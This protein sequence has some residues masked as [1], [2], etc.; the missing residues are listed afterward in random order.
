MDFSNRLLTVK[1][2]PILKHLDGDERVGVGEVPADVEAKDAVD[3]T[4]GGDNFS[5][6]S[7]VLSFQGGTAP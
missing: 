3:G 6:P 7:P 5:E 4:A 2:C 1:C